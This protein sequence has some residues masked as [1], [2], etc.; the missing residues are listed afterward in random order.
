MRGDARIPFANGP[1]V[2]PFYPVAS[3]KEDMTVV[4]SRNDCVKLID[5][6]ATVV[7]GIP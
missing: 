2:A 7:G 3:L 5:R 1:T 4:Y 6:A